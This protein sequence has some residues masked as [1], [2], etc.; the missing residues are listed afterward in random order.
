MPHLLFYVQHI[1]KIQLIISVGENV[2]VHADTDVSPVPE[3]VDETD[4]HVPEIDTPLPLPQPDDLAETVSYAEDIGDRDED[5]MEI[6][7][8]ES[9]AGLDVETP[10]NVHL[11][12]KL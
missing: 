5:F 2:A 9:V 12:G 3:L 10:E 8:E 7:A 4:M 6:E 1:I 11:M